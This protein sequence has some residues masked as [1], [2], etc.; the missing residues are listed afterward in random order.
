MKKN[1]KMY[2]VIFPMWLL[3]FFP[4]TWIIVLPANFVIDLAILALTLRALKVQRLGKYIKSSILKVWIFGF[5]SDIIGALFMFLMYVIDF[6]YQTE[7]GK[8]WYENMSSAIAYQPF[9][10]IFSFLWVTICVLIA[11]V[12]IYFFNYKISFKHL[13][14]TDAEKKFVALTLAILTAPYLFY[15]PTA[16]FF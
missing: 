16:W 15:L 10:S 4:L 12:C 6:D 14:L 11:G 2:N 9:Q 7:L 8:W 13:E 5:A 3:I 1:I